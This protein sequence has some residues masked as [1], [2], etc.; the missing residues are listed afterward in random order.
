[1][2]IHIVPYEPNLVEEVKKFNDRLRSANACP[3]PL[4]ES[5]PG[6]LP[7]LATECGINFH[8]FVAVDGGGAVRGGYF[9]RSQPFL[10][11]KQVYTVGH[12][13]S[14]LSEGVIDKRYAVVGAL[15]LSHALKVQPLL[16]AMGM[17]GLQNP[18]PRIVKAMGWAIYEVPFFFRVLNGSRFFR[19]LGPLRTS[20]LR[21][22][23][24]DALS[25]SGIGHVALRIIHRFRT[26]SSLDRRFKLEPIEAFESW[27]DDAWEQTRERYSFS[28]VRDSRYL[29]FLYP[30]MRGPFGG[31]R[32]HEPGG[33][34]G[35]VQFLRCEPR[36]TSFFGQ[37]RVLAL[38]DGVASQAAIPSLILSVIKE[39]ERERM[40]LVFSNQMHSDWTSALRNCG[41]LE[42]PSN[43]LL[44]ISK[45]LIEL[46]DPLTESVPGIH[47]NRGDG[48]GCVNLVS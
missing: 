25:A 48:D 31:I 40:D 18:L 37:M 36:N 22:F 15:L 45:G 30:A 10:I 39:A 47:F 43:Y 33:T 5:V 24:A 29:Q 23:L 2:G 7:P 21:S 27:A 11:R 6:K 3:F 20:T 14:P 32:L 13:T 38:V 9:I 1:M 41:F 17:G 35:W 26:H 4:S 42:G 44:A 8:H 12:F 34:S 16:F 19:N 28:A 46:L